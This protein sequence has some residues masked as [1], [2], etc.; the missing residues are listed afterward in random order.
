[1]IEPWLMHTDPQVLRAFGS[2]PTE[3]PDRVVV[4][5]ERLGK[6][7]RQA[8]AHGLLGTD[9]TIRPDDADAVA[10]VRAEGFDRVVCRIDPVGPRTAEQVAEVRRQGGGAV[11]VPMWR[12][13]DELTTVLDAA[14]GLEVGAMVETVDALEHCAALHSMGIAFVFIGLVDLAIDRGTCSIFAPLADGTLDRI[15]GDL[16]GVPFG[17]GGLTLPDRGHPIPNR[18]L[19]GEMVRL[20]ASFSFMRRSFL[21]DVAGHDPAAAVRAIREATVAAEQ[22]T[23]HQVDTDRA[24]LVGI[25]QELLHAR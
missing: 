16:A 13:L 1:M 9:T 18:L 19:V 14:D 8:G 10:R 12:T 11:L 5:W 17:F 22:R 6:H 25:I 2:S 20:G 21:D 23:P 15:A 24:R 7:E 3:R 4:D